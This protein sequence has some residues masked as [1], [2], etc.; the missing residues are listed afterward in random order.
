MTPQ[1]N[2]ARNS[3]A[4]L[5]PT[6]TH[7]SSPAVLFFQTKADADGRLGSNVEDDYPVKNIP[8]WKSMMKACD[9]RSNLSLVKVKT[10]K[11]DRNN[12]RTY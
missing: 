4:P 2:K 8:I 5:D 1:P 3:E 10:N 6:K 11:E 12:S 9:R 7:S